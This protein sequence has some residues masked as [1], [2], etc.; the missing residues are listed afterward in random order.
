MRLDK[1]DQFIK[2]IYFSIQAVS[3]LTPQ[4]IK[5]NADSIPRNVD[6]SYSLILNF[7][8]KLVNWFL[9][10]KHLKE[11]LQNSFSFL[12]NKNADMD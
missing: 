2:S 6:K 8:H 12:I 9:E 5:F 3:H 7:D 10:Y 4:A 11:K 1:V